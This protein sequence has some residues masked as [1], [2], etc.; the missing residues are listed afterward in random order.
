MAISATVQVLHDGARNVVM[1]FTGVSDG[2]PGETN[3]VK[4]DVSE[5]V[6]PPRSVKIK[7]IANYDVSGGLLQMSWG[8]DDPVPFLELANV[9]GISYEGI[10]GLKNGGGDTATGDILF[11]TLGFEAGSS[12]SVTLEMT[13]K[14]V[15]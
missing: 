11:T 6:P 3:V 13:K 15:P 5:L 12:Y 10:G 1:Q 2:G 14:F 7:R 4:V 9:N 8:A